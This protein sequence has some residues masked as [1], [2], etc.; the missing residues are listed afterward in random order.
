[1][2]L[3]KYV[4]VLLVAF[5]AMSSVS[6]A[7]NVIWVGGGS[8]ALFLEVGQAAA[9]FEGS[10]ACIWSSAALADDD[11]SSQDNRPSK[12]GLSADVQNGKVWV[13]YGA[14]TGSCTTPA[15]TYN[16]YVYMSLDSVLGNRCFFEVDTK[17]N[18][19]GC[20]YTFT[21][22]TAEAAPQN[23]NYLAASGATCPG[24]QYCDSNVALPSSV[25]NA[26]N[27][28]HWDFAGSDVRP[29]DA[30]FASYRI[31]TPCGQAVY[32]QPFDQ[33][34]RQTYGLGY[35]TSNT[36]IG[37]T[38]QS[39]F[40]T[41]LFTVLDFNINGDDPI[42][43]SQAV[44]S[45]QTTTVGAQPIIVSASPAA[46]WSGVND[47]NGFLL[48]L[49][50][51][52]VLARTQD[53]PGGLSGS[54]VQPVTVLVREPLSGT[55]NT[56]EFSIPNS[57]QFHGSQDDN[58]CNGTAFNQNPMLLASANGA[59]VRSGYGYNGTGFGTRRRVIGT[60]E[61]VAQLQA[62]T[63]TD[64]RIGYW[65]WSAGNGKAFSTSNGKYLTVNGVDPFFN[66]YSAACA[67]GQTSGCNPVAPGVIPTGSN[68]S[69][70]N[71]A[72]LQNGD[73]PAWSPLRLLTNSTPP[74]GLANI[75]SGLA[76]INPTQHDYIAPANMTVWHSHFYLPAIGSEVSSNGNV[77][78]D[79]PTVG[80]GTSICTTAGALAEMGGD[81]GGSNVYTQA[82][83]D[84][85]S[86]YGQTEGL[87]N[88][89]N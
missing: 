21:P 81:V 22:S 36:G 67:T 82:N 76:T 23:T 53:I 43:T 51:Q 50:Y 17:D 72:N 19:S 84:F 37:V 27:G 58:N 4:L 26:I 77:N 62:A 28:K 60:S 34:L 46:T 70:I 1:M 38:I 42:N 24:G 13:V 61:M 69:Y 18:S 66:S 29:E 49:F 7:Q 71:F 6:N 63:T 45:Y 44:Q 54:S 75:L 41:T 57:S 39:D 20:I 25:Y 48:T 64:A 16:V 80:T 11:I 89:A 65:F 52:G 83:Y 40:S 12:Y 15:G 33:G 10:G 9:A 30:K 78:L 31:L 88:K 35:Q 47:I 87:I 14:G 79:V 8:S 73:Y 86:D 5:C 2:K 85:C 59:E 74:A 55:Y 3:M 68:T 32:R 56:F